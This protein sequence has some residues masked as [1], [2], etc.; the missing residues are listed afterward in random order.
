MV[1]MIGSQSGCSL[2]CMPLSS[3]PDSNITATHLVTV[4]AGGRRDRQVG[5]LRT[6]KNRAKKAG[7]EKIKQIRFCIDCKVSE[8]FQSGSSRC[9]G[10]S[11][12]C[13]RARSARICR[14]GPQ[15]TTATTAKSTTTVRVQHVAATMPSKRS[16]QW[17]ILDPVVTLQGTWA[18]R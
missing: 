18:G 14:L 9:M 4:S 10:Q 13:E 7:C 1:D 17:P 5:G 3:H 12:N 15:T 8:S 2:S 16:M 11:L 6:G